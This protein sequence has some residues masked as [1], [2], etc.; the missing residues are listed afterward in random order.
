MERVTYK[1]LI[2]DQDNKLC[3]IEGEEVSLSKREYELLVFLLTHPNHVYSREE[4]IQEIWKSPTAERA[5]DVNISR[6]RRKLN[7]Y[8]KCIVTRSGFGYT[9]KKEIED[10]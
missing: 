8:G 10:E 5:V 4:L 7:D 6:L 2:V 1:D 3:T 9:F